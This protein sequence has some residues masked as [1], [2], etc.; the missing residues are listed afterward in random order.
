MTARAVRASERMANVVRDMLV[1]PGMRYLSAWLKRGRERDAFEGCLEDKQSGGKAERRCLMYTLIYVICLC[2]AQRGTAAMGD[3]GE[4]RSVSTLG[5]NRCRPFHLSSSAARTVESLRLEEPTL[6]PL[7]R[8][9]QVRAFGSKSQ[10]LSPA[11]MRTSMRPTARRANFCQ[12]ESIDERLPSLQKSA[13][14]A[15]CPEPCRLSRTLRVV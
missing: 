13:S 5:Y 14:R 11:A 9:G 4:G 2:C 15:G 6:C 8:P 1:Q 7:Q 10:L 3:K 12:R